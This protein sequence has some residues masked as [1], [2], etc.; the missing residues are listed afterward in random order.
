VALAAWGIVSRVSERAA[1]AA[2]TADLAIPTV[3]TIKPASS[4]AAEQLVLPGSVQAYNEAP[5]F[6]RLIAFTAISSQPGKLA[7][8]QRTRATNRHK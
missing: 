6:A 8:S 2:Q 1:L 4:S 5:I 7:A 3:S